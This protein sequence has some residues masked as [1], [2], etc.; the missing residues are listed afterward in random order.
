MVRAS[1][2]RLLLNMFLIGKKRLVKIDKY[3][4][5]RCPPAHAGEEGRWEHYN[6]YIEHPMD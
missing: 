5:L 1:K 3:V 2:L 4:F 6:K